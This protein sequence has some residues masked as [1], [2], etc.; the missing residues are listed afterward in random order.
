[1][2]LLAT[3][4]TKKAEPLIVLK[5]IGN[6]DEIV[7][8]DSVD[9]YS[10]F[11]WALA[12]KFTASSEEAEAAAREIFIDIWRHKECKDQAQS[13]EELLIGLSARRLVKYLQAK[14]NKNVRQ[15]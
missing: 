7:T 15:A 10:D 5:R 13:A 12:K 3:K 1:M 14:P 11:I 6:K 2:T 9:A 8:V 4:T